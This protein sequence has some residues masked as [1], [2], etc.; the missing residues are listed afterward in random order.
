M[1]AAPTSA[2]EPMAQS[3]ELSGAYR[4]PPI[5]RMRAPV[6][7][8]L[9]V[10]TPGDRYEREADA[11]ADRVTAGQA[12]PAI[13]TIPPGGLAAQRAPDDDAD[14]A[15]GD[16]AQELAQAKCSPCEQQDASV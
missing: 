1:P 7:A 3:R 16:D 13:S 11:V 10:G 9:S 6:Q 5:V 12:A 4:S 8:K 15:P 2:E 14:D